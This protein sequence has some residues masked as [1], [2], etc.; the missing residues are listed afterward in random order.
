MPK[1]IVVMTYN[2]YG[3]H[4]RPGTILSFA[5]TVSAKALS[6]KMVASAGGC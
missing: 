4:Y 5:L 2:S 3:M 1:E 6:Q